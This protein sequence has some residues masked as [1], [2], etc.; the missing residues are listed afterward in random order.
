MWFIDKLEG[1][2]HYHIPG[3]LRLKGNVNQDTLQY[4]LQTIISRHEVLR[5]VIREKNGIP[6][7]E[8]LS[9]DNW[10]LSIIDITGD[11]QTDMIGFIEQPFDL[12]ADYMLRAGL[13]KIGPDEHLLVIATHHIA[14]DGWSATVMIKEVSELYSAYIEGH[15]A[16]L[17]PLPVQ[18]RIMRSGKE[19][20][21]KMKF[22]KSNWITG[23]GNCQEWKHCNYQLT[24]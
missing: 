18:Y 4:A 13:G 20:I 24:F 10:E 1:S 16:Q 21:L 19:L 22:C 5:T 11:L 12:A 8:V 2:I 15:A 9:P 14:S 23:K 6:Y 3:A 7:Q 17:A